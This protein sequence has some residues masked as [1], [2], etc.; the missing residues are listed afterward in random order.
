MISVI[1]YSSGRRKLIARAL[2]S[3]L[4]QASQARSFREIIVVDN[5]PTHKTGC[6]IRHLAPQGAEFRYFWCPGVTR[7]VAL[8]FGVRKATSEVVMFLDETAEM[9][10]DSLERVEAAF[11]AEP[12]ANVVYG[13]GVIRE[14]E[15]WL[16]PASEDPM[17]R[18]HIAD[19]LYLG[20]WNIHP[21]TYACRRRL[22]VNQGHY[23]SDQF[24]R[25]EDLDLL[26]RIAETERFQPI[27]ED[28]AIVLEP[29]ADPQRLV[30]L[31]QLLT[32]YIP[33]FSRR[34]GKLQIRKHL[35]TIE[36]DVACRFWRSGCNLL[37]FRHACRAL[38]LDRQPLRYWLLRGI[39]HSQLYLN[40]NDRI[41]RRRRER[42]AA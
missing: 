10:P 20:D 13:R 29:S 40:R 26:L 37:A 23:F 27:G 1:L 5:S 36:Y 32:S 35:A 8:N 24:S 7:G 21:S 34:L 33:A 11:A 41:S 6:R 38:E 12:K 42:T 15:G 18:G 39:V 14:R 19:A 28:V 16:S 2:R 25:W 9:L 22:F 4:F 31:G 3:V 30:E 17:P